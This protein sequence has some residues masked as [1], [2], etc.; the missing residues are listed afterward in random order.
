M[1]D[2][3]L[4]ASS[5]K[6]SRRSDAISDS[7]CISESKNTTLHRPPKA[8]IRDAQLL[9]AFSPVKSSVCRD[10]R[11]PRVELLRV[12][13]QSLGVKTRTRKD[14]ISLPNFPTAHQRGK[15]E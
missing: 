6:L 13:P 11:S 10:G 7:K 15:G 8:R 12:S 9:P 4:L 2:G 14:R 5:F 3:P 1:R